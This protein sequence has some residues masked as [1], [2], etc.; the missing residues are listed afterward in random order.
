MYKTNLET[1]YK[2]F[3]VKTSRYQSHDPCNIT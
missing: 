3:D 2:Y 1:V